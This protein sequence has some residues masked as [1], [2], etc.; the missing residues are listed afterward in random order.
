MGGFLVV[1]MLVGLI[2]SLFHMTYLSR[3]V[4]SGKRSQTSGAGFE[5]TLFERNARLGGVWSDGYLNFG[6]Q[7]LAVYSQFGELGHVSVDGRTFAFSLNRLPGSY[8]SLSSTRR[9]K[10]PR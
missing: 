3:L 4:A 2:I 10:L 7:V 8:R 1:G 5:C 6:A 9:L